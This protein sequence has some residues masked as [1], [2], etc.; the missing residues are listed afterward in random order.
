[1]L[2]AATE[3]GFEK[4][5]KQYEDILAG[6]FSSKSAAGG[7]QEW[8][9]SNNFWSSYLHVCIITLYYQL[10]LVF[11]DERGLLQEKIII[12]TYLF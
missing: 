3:L 7:K 6:N 4:E 12:T 10:F 8:I 9:F 2:K 11:I 5:K 1:M